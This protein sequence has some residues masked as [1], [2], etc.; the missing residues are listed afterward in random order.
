ME[1]PPLPVSVTPLL[2]VGP[3]VGK[4]P[5]KKSLLAP[6]L[7]FWPLTLETFLLL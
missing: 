1:A 4:L 2:S 7:V 3:K 5:Q 6:S